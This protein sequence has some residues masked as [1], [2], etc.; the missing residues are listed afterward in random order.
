MYAIRSYYVINA[1]RGSLIDQQA[2][3][4]LLNHDH[5]RFVLLDVFEQEPLDKTHPFWSHPKVLMTPHVAADTIPEEAV[6]QVAANVRALSNGLPVTG[7]VD[8]SQG[9]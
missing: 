2:L 4:A 8:R 7:K 5:F 1:G 3:L 9:Y 6:E